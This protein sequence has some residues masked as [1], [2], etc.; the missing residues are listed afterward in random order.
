MALINSDQISTPETILDAPSKVRSSKPISNGSNGG[1]IAAIIGALVIGLFGGIIAGMQI[2]KSTSTNGQGGQSAQ[3]GMGRMGQNRGTMGTVTSVSNS[4]IT[5]KDTR[6]NESVTYTITSDTK[7]TNDGETAA[8]S[9]I[10]VG[11]T[12]MVRTGSSSSSNGSSSTKTATRIEI[13]PTMGGEQ[14]S[15]GGPDDTTSSGSATTQQNVQ[16]N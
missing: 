4:S 10:A 1:W 15:A 7:V 6:Q 13:N 2:G 11:D 14:G 12:V 16:T 8:V 9:D 3:G 5:V